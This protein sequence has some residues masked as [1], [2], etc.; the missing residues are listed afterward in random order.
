ML[1]VSQNDSEVELSIILLFQ[2]TI[3]CWRLECPEKRNV[4]CLFFRYTGQW[5]CY[6]PNRKEYQGSVSTACTTSTVESACMEC[7][8]WQTVL[9]RI[10]N[11][12]FNTSVGKL[13]HQ[14]QGLVLS[15]HGFYKASKHNN[16]L[17]TEM[18]C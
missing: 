16:L 7:L 5:D 18:Y 13:E 12:S 8:Q 9:D 10:E 17:S 6:D 1:N 3:F 2:R 11:P 15:Y 4:K 14:Y